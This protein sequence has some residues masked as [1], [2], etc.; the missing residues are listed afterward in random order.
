MTGLSVLEGIPGRA[1]ELLRGVASNPVIH[2]H[3]AAAGFQ[4]S[5]YQEGW[6]RLH[7]ASGYVPEA[8]APLVKS[9]VV[10]AMQQLDRWDEDGFR[11]IRSG[12]ER[13][14]PAQAAFVF[15]GGLAASEGAQAVIGVKTLLFRLNELESGHE[16]EATRNEDHAALKTLSDRGITKAERSRLQGLVD[17]AETLTEPPV[18]PALAASAARQQALLALYA[19]YK[20]WAETARSV[21][22][23]RSHLITLGLAKRKAP[24]KLPEAPPTPA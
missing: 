3:L 2:S 5:D 9:T 21:V 13:L 10:V 18:L 24:K 8:T 16:R 14:H 22:K 11:R 20:D 23:K 4:S 1:L 6:K 12:L 19:W 15:A 7:A 17:T